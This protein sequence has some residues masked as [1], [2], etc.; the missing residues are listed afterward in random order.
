MENRLF[1]SIG[2]EVSLLGFGCMRL[3]L[4]DPEKQDIDYA[5]AEAMIDRAVARGVNYFDTDRV[6]HEG[7]SGPFIGHA[8]KKHQRDKVYLATKMPTWEVHAAEDVERIFSEQLKKCRVDYFDFYLVHALR[9]EHYPTVRKAASTTPC[10]A[11]K[12][13]V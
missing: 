9:T 7:K 12:S 3:P 5:Q 4:L 11:R 1:P 8:L 10:G 13:K 2:K 6:Y